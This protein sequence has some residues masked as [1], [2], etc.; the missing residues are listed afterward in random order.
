[1]VSVPQKFHQRIIKD[2]KGVDRHSTDLDRDPSF[3]KDSTNL[4]LTYQKGI[5]GRLGYSQVL[6]AELYGIHTYNFYDVEE[7]TQKEELLVFNGEFFRVKEIYFEINGTAEVTFSF[8][9]SVVTTLDNVAYSTPCLRVAGT[10]FALQDYFLGE[11]WE[12]VD[13]LSGVSLVKMPTA[14]K[15]P[16]LGWSKIS[17][18]SSSE[19][20]QTLSGSY[21]L[22]ENDLIATYC[23]S[24]KAPRA[25]LIGTIAGSTVTIGKTGANIVGLEMRYDS[26]LGVASFFSTC[27]TRVAQG[28]SSTNW[29]VY[30]NALEAIPN[31]NVYYAWNHSSVEIESMAKIARHSEPEA[32]PTVSFTDSGDVV[33]ACTDSLPDF[34]TTTSKL[35]NETL[36]YDTGEITYKQKVAE[37]VGRPLKYDGK[38]Q[39]HAGLYAPDGLYAGQFSNATTG[40][41]AMVHGTYKYVLIYCFTDARGRVFY[42]DP[43]ENFRSITLSGMDNAVNIRLDTD[44]SVARGVE[45]NPGWQAVIN[46]N[47]TSATIRLNTPCSIFVGDIIYHAVGLDVGGGSITSTMSTRKVVSI[48]STIGSNYIEIT[49]DA[50]LT[51]VAGEIVAINCKTLICRTKLGGNSFYL[52]TEM[53]TISG[54]LTKSTASNVYIDE[55]A[56]TSIV[57]PVAIPDVGFERTPPPRTFAMTLHNGR[58]IYCGES[59]AYWSL[60][61]A[62]TESIEHVPRTNSIAIGGTVGGRLIGASSAGESLYIFRKRGI[63]EIKGS[64]LNSLG[65]AELSVS[66]LTEEDGGLS[67]TNGL[68]TVGGVLIAHGANSI[69]GLAQNSL[70]PEIGKMLS[71]DYKSMWKNYSAVLHYDRLQDQLRVILNNLSSIDSDSK[72]FIL[73]CKSF[74]GALAQDSGILFSRKAFSGSWFKWEFPAHNKPTLGFT[75]FN[76]SDYY[77][78]TSNIKRESNALYASARPKLTRFD[79]IYKRFSLAELNTT[80]SNSTGRLAY[81]DNGSPIRYN[82]N[83]TPLHF[84]ELEKLKEFCR[85]KLWRFSNTNEV[86]RITDFIANVELFYNLSNNLN[87]TAP[88]RATTTISFPD[89]RDVSAVVDLSGVTATALELKLEVY[90]LFKTL[91]LSGVVLDLQTPYDFDDLNVASND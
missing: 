60:P 38:R 39:Y 7:D 40:T 91:S 76:D 29:K 80:P 53:P 84:N 41:G 43:S 48:N 23:S 62:G 56:D 20:S 74:T 31:P 26:W 77:I 47:A 85:L 68:A 24:T 35:R 34:Y 9:P 14:V 69:F 78:G 45:L 52:V 71:S 2:F 32:N 57:E 30:Y 19:V 16:Y 81:C 13:A 61:D 67:S 66:T 83:T 63:Y 28:T 89:A 49:L 6:S 73:D 8:N 46:A 75:T 12:A 44:L 90:E 25:I 36:T 1:M 51:V 27:I 54:F 17:P 65:Y 88:Q 22:S 82:F 55:K 33:Y 11:L 58:A 3:F 42:S 72:I 5:V 37:Y 50:S 18:I 15:T 10:N 4:E 79:G 87:S 21:D 70:F 86:E 64:F 59:T